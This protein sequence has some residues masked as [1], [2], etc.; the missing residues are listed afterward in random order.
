M[1]HAAAAEP[2]STLATL[3]GEVV[4]LRRAADLLEWDERV[5][6]PRGG[7]SAHGEMAA[8]IRRLAHEKFTREEVGRVLEAAQAAS[9]DGDRDSDSYRLMTV[10]AHDFAKAV[11][12]PADFVAEHAQAISAAQHAWGDARAHSD[13]EAFRPHLETIVELKQRYVS[14]FP[15]ADHPYDVLLDDYEPGMRS[16]DVQRV[17]G[18]LRPRQVAL[19]RAIAERPQVD[20]ACLE[21]PYAEQDLWA[22]AV[23]VVT[24]FGFDW[25]RGRQDK[26]AH[27]FATALGRDDVRITTRWV[28]GHP[29]SLL[30]GTMHEAGHALYEQGVSPAWHRTMLEGGASLGIHESQSRL[31]ENLVGRSRPFWD[32]FFPS[33]Q[34]RFPLQLGAVSA[35]HFYRAV[36]KVERSPIRVEADEATYNL[37]VMLRVEMEI[38]LIE[39]RMRV[40]DLPEIWNARMHEYLGLTP[41]ND[42]SGVLQD[43]HWAAGLFGY[44]ATYALGNLISAQI[45]E[46]YLRA[47]PTR[48]EEIRRGDF[49]ALLAWLG[50]T[51]HQHGRKYQP[52]E[53]VRRITGA[54]IDPD[55]YLRYLEGKYGEIYGMP[56]A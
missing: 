26:S 18:V 28:E 51:L 20:A 47:H 56:H 36:N 17:F 55:P 53:L 30:F 52:Q 44:F 15:G 21:V 3:I 27:P 46:R 49:S 41:A 37:H 1:P 9:G 8:T 48:D 45:W 50:P 23:E 7:A 40:Q 24:A 16:A 12:V 39:G 35:D 11:R 32:H 6:M 54:D 14:F 5:Y 38:G 34:A 42:A 10:T 4:D 25:A 22:F 31:W 33:L 43:I 13:F 29:L 19:I 2:F